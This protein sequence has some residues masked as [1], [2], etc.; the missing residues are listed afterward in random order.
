M[1]IKGETYE[2][3][4][5]AVNALIESMGGA[6]K[7]KA[8]YAKTLPAELPDIRKRNR[9]L[10]DLWSSAERSLLYD[11]THPA[12]AQGH[13]IRVCPQVPGW[14]LYADRTIY[15]THVLTALCKIGAELGIV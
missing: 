9:M 7:V 12:F 6:E 4:K 5:R 13:W 11:D 14:N 8:F 10:W 3:I 2:T 1:K 15:D